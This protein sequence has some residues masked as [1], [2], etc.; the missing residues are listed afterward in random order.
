MRNIKRAVL[1]VLGG[2]VVT[3]SLLAA[4]TANA[5]V[6]VNE[7]GVGFVGKGDV[8][9]ALGGINNEAIQGLVDNGKVNF[10][11]V[12]TDT[13]RVVNAWA[14]GNA[15]NPVSLNAHE[16]T[17]TTQ[18]GVNAAVNADP[19]KKNGQKQWTGFD[20]K[21]LDSMRTVVTGE[22][23]VVS[24]TVTY[25]TFSYEAWTGQWT[26]VPYLDNKGNVKYKNGE[27]IMETRTTDQMPVDENGNL[28]TEGDNKAVLSVDKVSSIGGLFVND[29]PLPNTPVA[30]PVA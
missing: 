11:Y 9:T 20:L 24:P 19:R 12:T 13:Y 16:V 25:A 27:K 26:Q 3:A 28:Y 5:S 6:A 21:G 22:I 15:D 1:A 17:V 2:A 10:T 29:V 18:V 30:V 23:P 14:T 8:Q 7:S 4:G